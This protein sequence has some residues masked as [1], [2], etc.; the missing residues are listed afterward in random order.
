[1]YLLVLFV[2]NCYATMLWW[3]NKVVYIYRPK[4]TTYNAKWIFY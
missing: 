2:L 4:Q 1:M 3:W